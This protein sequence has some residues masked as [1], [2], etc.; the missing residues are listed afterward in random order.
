MASDI[1]ILLDAVVERV[2]LPCLGE[3]DEGDCLA[4]IVQ[5]QATC[6]DGVHDRRVVDHA[7]WDVQGTR[8]EEHVRVRGCPI[9]ITSLSW[10]RA[11]EK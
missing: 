3:E 4:E 1:R 7:C 9:Q 5:L 2:R 10:F 11:G 8:A 6:A